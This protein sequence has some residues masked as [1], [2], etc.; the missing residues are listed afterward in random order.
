MTEKYV[1][2]GDFLNVTLGGTVAKND[3]DVIGTGLLG[4]ALDAGVSGEII[5]YGIRGVYILPKVTAAVIAQGE[6]VLWDVSA[7]KVDDD[8]ATPA[9][10]DFLCGMAF[11]AKGSSDTEIA[12]LINQPSPSVT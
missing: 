9:A 3:V 4:V 6:Q 12:V 8:Q 5:A 10:G 7:G 1:Q 11:E 2:K